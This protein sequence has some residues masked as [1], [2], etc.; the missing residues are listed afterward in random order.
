MI[1]TIKEWRMRRSFVVLACVCV[2]VAASAIAQT[3]AS[4]PK[5]GPE[6]KKL[7]AFVGTWTYEGEAKK[8]AF[9][10]AG[11]ITGTDV[12]EMLPG[13]FAIMHRWDEKNPLGAVK[14]TE[15]WAYDPIKKTYTINYFTSL[16]E[17]GSGTFTLNG[18]TWTAVNS[19]IT[20]EGKM[21]YG[22]GSATISPTTIT[23]KWDASSDG[24]TFV[25]AFEGKW[26]KAK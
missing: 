11:K 26:T 4:A 24:K 12:Y 2:L 10:P 14:G 16:G 8:N 19:G 15:I 9:G 20:Y 18:N 23:V 21:G 6:H 13:G 1:F 7:E 22:K 17:I 25:P 3:S 5:P